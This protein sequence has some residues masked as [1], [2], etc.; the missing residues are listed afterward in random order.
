MKSKTHQFQ[1]DK[2]VFRQFILN[3]LKT[4]VTERN[5]DIFLQTAPIFA[6]K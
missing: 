1:V 4:A 3:D 2:D 5:L 6:Q